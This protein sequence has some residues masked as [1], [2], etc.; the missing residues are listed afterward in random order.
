M[1]A[2]KAAAVQSQGNATGSMVWSHVLQSLRND[3]RWDEFKTVVRMICAWLTFAQS[4]AGNERE[5]AILRTILDAAG[6][7][8]TSEE[9]DARH[10]IRSTGPAVEDLK[11]RQVGVAARFE[12][13]DVLIRAMGQWQAD[14]THRGKT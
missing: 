10:R 2:A 12:R 7:K 4:S 1:C 6:K 9:L 5:G 13:Y 14:S 11:R 8:P 3:P